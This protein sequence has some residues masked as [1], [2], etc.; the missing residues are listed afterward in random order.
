VSHRVPLDPRFCFISFLLS[1]LTRT[2]SQVHPLLSR[3]EMRG[4]YP[5]WAGRG[6]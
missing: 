3:M 2:S 5:K 1:V 4:L 6:I